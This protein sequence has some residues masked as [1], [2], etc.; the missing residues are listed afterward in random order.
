MP[1][2]ALTTL[3]AS[4]LLVVGLSPSA[5]SAHSGTQSYLYVSI[6]DD[7]VIGRVEIPVADLGP[8]L[9]LEFPSDRRVLPAAVQAARVDI[10]TY[11]AENTALGA[12][13][14]TWN[15]EY[16]D[17]SVLPTSKGAYVVL[18]FVVADDLDGAQRDFVANFSVIIESN[19]ER[20][21][22]LLIEDDWRGA[23]FDNGSEHLLGFSAGQTE[24]PVVLEDASTLSSMAAIRGLASDEVR[25]QI[26]LLLLVAAVAAAM[27]LVPRRHDES[28]ARPLSSVIR[29][30]PT[31]A[32]AFVAGSMIPLWLVGLRV[33]T[34]PTRVTA[35]VVVIALALVALY[36]TLARL[37]GEF[38]R[39]DTAVFTI[40]GVAFGLGLGAGFVFDDL[41]RARPVLGLVAFTVGA[42]IAAMLVSIFVAVPLLLLR[43]TRYITAIVVVMSVVFAGYAI[44]WA[45]EI[46]ANDDWPIEKFAN[47]LRVWPR[48]FWFVLLAIALAAGIRA[49]EHRGGRLRP[50]AASV[51]P[52]SEPADSTREPVST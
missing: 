11:I 15:L 7:G 32:G 41:D 8:A 47:P 51:S 20:D 29:S 30:T 17:L 6:F 2:L 35:M 37:R 28:V 44:A 38:R 27:L 36:L 14:S 1:R 42:M 24:Q 26:D 9:G 5:A 49:I 52:A 21:A 13:G 46:L 12:D 25:E 39:F 23:T 33:I 45:A 48:N 4:L 34:L 10:E 50:V 43:R 31:R 19:P 22:L 40:A 16:G 3:L 18:D